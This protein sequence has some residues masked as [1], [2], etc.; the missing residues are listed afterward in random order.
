MVKFQFMSELSNIA[1]RRDLC[2]KRTKTLVRRLNNLLHL[3]V[4]ILPIHDS[5]KRNY[6]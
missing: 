4:T 5:H 1:L 6:M 2:E 3:Q